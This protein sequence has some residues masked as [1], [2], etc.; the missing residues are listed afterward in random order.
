[1]LVLTRKTQEQIHI[2]DQITITILKVHGR[3]VKVGI[4]APR[5]VR[6]I[7]AELPAEVAEN[8]AVPPAKQSDEQPSSAPT[9]LATNRAP[10]N[11]GEAASYVET[12]IDFDPSDASV[13]ESC[14]AN[15]P[16]PRVDSDE[17]DRGSRLPLRAPLRAP[18]QA[19]HRR[20]RV[21]PPQNGSMLRALPLIELPTSTQ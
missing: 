15:P 14:E 11:P 2:G 8:F 16:L 17:D 13:A 19:I 20:F 3:S 12:E 10:W 1:M 4:Q 18:L 5:E 7:R 9:V 21:I 6:V